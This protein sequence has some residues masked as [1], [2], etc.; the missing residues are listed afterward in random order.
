M[1]K[2]TKGLAYHPGGAISSWSPGRAAATPLELRDFRE[3]Q[4]PSA[5]WTTYHPTW[6]DTATD[7]ALGFFGEKPSLATR[8]R[9]ERLMGNATPAT[10]DFVSPVD[11]TPAGAVF[12]AEEA[13]RNYKLG[14]YSGAAW[15]AVGAVPGGAVSALG[16]GAKTL[17]RAVQRTGDISAG[18][19]GL[20]DFPFDGSAQVFALE[21]TG[22]AQKQSGR[23]LASRTA[24]L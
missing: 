8:T 19:R 1:M 23:L 24:N 4:V 10:S 16:K 21:S 18:R 3:E 5:V 9:V 15:D 6:R 2:K 12:S 17:K 14:N 13:Y 20:S 22:Y 7:W 11:F